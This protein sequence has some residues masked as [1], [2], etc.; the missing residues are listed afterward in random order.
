[1][2]LRVSEHTSILP[3]IMFMSEDLISLWRM[4][5]CVA[6]FFTYLVVLCNPFV[7]VASNTESIY[8]YRVYCCKEHSI[9][10]LM[11]EHLTKIS[12]SHQG[13]CVSFAQEDSHE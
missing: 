9:V 6:L 1:V 11:T 5:I 10:Y 2:R 8:H 13:F 7:A 12:K 3:V 4:D